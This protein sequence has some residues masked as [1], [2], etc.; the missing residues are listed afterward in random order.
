MRGSEIRAVNH[1]YCDVYLAFQL[2]LLIYAWPGRTAK[3]HINGIFCGN[4]FGTIYTP[5]RDSTAN[6]INI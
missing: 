5:C 6:Q 3:K 1:V 2:L 4:T